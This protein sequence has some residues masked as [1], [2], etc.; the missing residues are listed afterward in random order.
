MSKHLIQDRTATAYANQARRIAGNENTFTMAEVAEL[1]SKVQGEVV[2]PENG[3]LIQAINEGEAFVLKSGKYDTGMVFAL[4]EP[5]KKRYFGSAN[6]I[7]NNHTFEKWLAPIPTSG[8]LIIAENFSMTATSSYSSKTKDIEMIVNVSEENLTLNFRCLYGDWEDYVLIDWGDGS[9][10]KIDYDN[11]SSGIEHTY[12][13]SGAYIIKMSGVTKIWYITAD[14]NTLSVISHITIP[15]GVHI[16][17]LFQDYPENLM[18]VTICYGVETLG[19]GTNAKYFKNSKLSGI[20]IPNTVQDVPKSLCSNVTTLKKVILDYGIK[21]INNDAF[22]YCTGLT[23][24]VIPA[25][26]VNIFDSAFNTC[27]GLTNVVIPNGVKTIGGYAFADCYEL[28]KVVIPETV[29]SI[30]DYAFRY[31]GGYPHIMDRR[32]VTVIY[33]AHCEIPATMFYDVRIK[34]F[35]I[36][37]VDSIV[38][39]SGAPMVRN[40]SNIYVPDS[41]VD[42]YKTAENWSTYASYIKPLSECEVDY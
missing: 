13:K 30:G 14:S 34:E 1:L 22:S 23:E 3:Y 9:T 33:N 29:E 31:I 4:P 26:V 11:W 15:Q 42:S 2:E 21:N 7:D 8:N 38:P 19:D 36:P 6:L 10:T 28:T 18:S 12:T 27:T 5:P 16:D 40:I 41:L 32:D 35:I 25:T 20:Y 37:Y 17:Y 39:W 24:I